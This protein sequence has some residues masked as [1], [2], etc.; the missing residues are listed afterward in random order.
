MSTTTLVWAIEAQAGD[1]PGW[2]IKRLTRF[3][4]SIPVLMKM[5]RLRTPATFDVGA[6]RNSGLNFYPFRTSAKISNE[7]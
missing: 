4:A 6:P 5:K 1:R 3:Q 2:L 7:Y